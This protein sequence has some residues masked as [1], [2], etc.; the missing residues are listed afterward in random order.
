MRMRATSQLPP[1]V[2][3]QAL[4]SLAFTSFCAKTSFL[5]PK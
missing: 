5:T 1:K 2:I 3:A 4:G